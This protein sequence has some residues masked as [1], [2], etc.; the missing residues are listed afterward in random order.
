LDILYDE[1]VDYTKRLAAAD[2]PC[3]LEVVP[4]AFHG[5]DAVAP[6]TAVAQAFI[7]SQIDFLRR[8]FNSA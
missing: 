4:G 6:K 1:A 7:A 3:D 8:A 5:F 2:V